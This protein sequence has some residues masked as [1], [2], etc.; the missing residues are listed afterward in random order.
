MKYFKV[1]W[2]IIFYSSVILTLSRCNSIE[3]LPME[4]LNLWIDRKEIEQ[5]VG[6]SFFNLEIIVPFTF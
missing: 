4:R 3:E 5:F 6:K 2:K 1:L